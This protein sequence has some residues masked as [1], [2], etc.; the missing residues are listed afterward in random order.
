MAKSRPSGANV[1]ALTLR[2][3]VSMSK[4]SMRLSSSEYSR[5]VS[6]RQEIKAYAIT[7]T[8]NQRK[9][10][11]ASFGHRIKITNKG[12]DKATSGTR[13]LEELEALRRL[14]QMLKRAV[15]KGPEQDK[16]SIKVLFS[17][18]YLRQKEKYLAKNIFLCLK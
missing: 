13:R 15:Y 9:I 16:K 17:F 8:F 2:E 4:K 6:L 1:H 18:T 10:F 14:P 11:N 3:N 12:I 7:K 5:M